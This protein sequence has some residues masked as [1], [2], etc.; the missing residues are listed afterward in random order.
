MLEGEAFDVRDC[1]VARTVEIVGERWTLL[2]LR[3]AFYG[4][5]RFDDFARRLGVARNVLTTRLSLLVDRGI[6]QRV[7]YRDPRQRLRNEYRL[8]DA[9]RDLLPAIIALMHWGDRYLTDDQGGP[10]SLQHRNC[11]HAV[12]IDLQCSVG[13]SGLVAREIEA[14]PRATALPQVR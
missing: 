9:G 7:P 11:G 13:H 14:T 1:S 8:T 3:E 12:L 6:L 5:R 10:V 2:I 4:V